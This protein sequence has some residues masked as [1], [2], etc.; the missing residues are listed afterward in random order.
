MFT[1]LWQSDS[2]IGDVWSAL[3]SQW[4]TNCALCEK[5]AEILR[6]NQLRALELEHLH[7][8]NLHYVLIMKEKRVSLL[9]L[10]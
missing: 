3:S 9:L 8:E 5:S 7:I 10:P 2:G 6:I 4:N 1:T